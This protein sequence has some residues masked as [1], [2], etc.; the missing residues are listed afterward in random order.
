MKELIPMDTYGMFA[1]MHDTARL[2]S[3][4]MAECFIKQHKDV[5]RAIESAISPNSRCV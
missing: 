4:K 3:L 5:I 2:N 1:D